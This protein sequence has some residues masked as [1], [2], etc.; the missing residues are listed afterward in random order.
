MNFAPL[1]SLRFV[2]LPLWL[3]MAW[4]SPL[5]SIAHRVVPYSP[6]SSS[7][8]G[9]LVVHYKKVTLNDERG[10]VAERYDGTESVITFDDWQSGRA[11]ADELHITNVSVSCASP[12]PSLSD[13]GSQE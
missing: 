2:L 4:L 6:V 3:A 13:Y 7:R 5:L 9:D 10:V 12:C 11:T 1:H 8:H